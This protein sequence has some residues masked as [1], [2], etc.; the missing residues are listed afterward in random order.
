MDAVHKAAFR[1][2]LGRSLY[3]NPDH[4]GSHSTKAVSTA[5]LLHCSTVV[6]V[7]LHKLC[8]FLAQIYW[9][10]CDNVIFCFV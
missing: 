3:M 6:P 8:W 7:V 5:L 2:T 9:H 1:G 4:V 10:V